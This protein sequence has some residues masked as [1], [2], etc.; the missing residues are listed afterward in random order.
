MQSPRQPHLDAIF[1]VLRYLKSSPDVGIFFSSTSDLRIS[2]FCDSNWAACPTTRRSITGY[3][4]FLGQSPIFWRSKK[5][6]TVSLSSAEA[7]YRSM[8]IATYELIWLRA[9]FSDLGIHPNAPMSLYCDNQTAIHITAN[10]V[11]MSAQNTLILIVMLCMN[12][13]KTVIFTV[14]NLF[15]CLCYSLLWMDRWWIISFLYFFCK[16]FMLVDKF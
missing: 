16:P 14:I 10:P 4:T 7:E 2:G 11:S 3:A 15:S 5:Q 6:T 13:Y 8:A 1:R 12:A 9:L